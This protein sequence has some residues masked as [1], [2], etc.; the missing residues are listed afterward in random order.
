MP[1]SIAGTELG[2]IAALCYPPGAPIARLILLRG[3]TQVNLAVSIDPLIDTLTSVG[4]GFASGSRLR[5]DS[6]GTVP[7]GTAA[8]VDYYAIVI[9]VDTYKLAASPADAGSATAI[10]LTDAGT[11]TVLV[12]EQILS[13]ADPINVLLKKELVGYDR[14]PVTV[15]AAV[16]NAGAAISPPVTITITNNGATGLTFRHAMLAVGADDTLGSSVGITGHG[17][18]FGGSDEVIAPAAA[19]GFDITIGVQAV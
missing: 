10:N 16:Y 12:N 8:G 9:D 5:I 17:I 18:Q 11:G 6:S 14:Q 1:V 13:I 7:G 2:R 19:A 4:H 3:D 15:S